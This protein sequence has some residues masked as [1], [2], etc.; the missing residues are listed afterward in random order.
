[1]EP[2]TS[3][4]ARTARHMACE[5]SSRAAAT[6]QS[7]DQ[8]HPPATRKIMARTRTSVVEPPT[9]DNEN[10][11]PATTPGRNAGLEEPKSVMAVPVWL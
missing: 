6:A 1:V 5:L 11:A 10:E 7:E 2:G 4:D 8:A 3:A 9:V